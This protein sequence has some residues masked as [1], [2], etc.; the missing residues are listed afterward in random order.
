MG[1]TWGW[2]C[3]GLGSWLGTT[4]GWRLGQGLALVRGKDCSM[5][6]VIGKSLKTYHR[7]HLGVGVQWIG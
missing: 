1:V 5:L 7:G 4:S 3:S 2:G 6:V